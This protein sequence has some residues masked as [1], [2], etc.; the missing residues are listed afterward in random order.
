M[1][2]WSMGLV[3]F[4]SEMPSTRNKACSDTTVSFGV[5]DAFSSLIVHEL[6]KSI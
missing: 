2:S 6:R 5:L 3:V 1:E 4:G